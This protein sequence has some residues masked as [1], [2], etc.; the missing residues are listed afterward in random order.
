MG[1]TTQMFFPQDRARWMILY[2]TLSF[3]TR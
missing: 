2:K 3:Q 1:K